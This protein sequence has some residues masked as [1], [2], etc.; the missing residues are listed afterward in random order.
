MCRKRLNRHPN[1]TLTQAIRRVIQHKRFPR[2]GFQS[3]T[4]RAE[5]AKR[6]ELPSVRRNAP[7]VCRK[8]PQAA[9]VNR[10]CTAS[11][12]ADAGFLGY[13]IRTS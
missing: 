4:T 13:P 12:S 8:T 1:F 2:H 10:P 7:E 6:R 5:A 9:A 11:P 3:R